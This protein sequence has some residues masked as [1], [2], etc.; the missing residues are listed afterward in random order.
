MKNIHTLIK[1][2]RFT[3]AL[4][5]FFFIVHLNKSMADNNQGVGVK[6]QP[7]GD[8]STEHLLEINISC[9]DL[10]DCPD[11]VGGLAYPV[12]EVIQ[13]NIKYGVQGCSQTL[14]APDQILTNRHCLL[15][16]SIKVGASCS[17]ITV[18]FPQTKQSPRESLACQTIL[19]MSPLYP[20][21]H[22]LGVFPD[23]VIL[24]LAH[25]VQRS[26][27]EVDTSGIPNKT[28][29]RTFP[30][31]YE[32]EKAKNLKV[33]TNSVKTVASGNIKKI[34][35]RSYMDLFS[36]I[37]YNHP[38]SPLLNF[39]CDSDT[40]YGNSGAGLISQEGKI[41]GVLSMSPPTS[42]IPLMG[43]RHNL[44]HYRRTITT[45]NAHCIPPLNADGSTA[46]AFDTTSVQMYSMG[47]FAST[48]HGQILSEALLEELEAAIAK[49][50]TIQWEDYNESFVAQI[51]APENTFEGEPLLPSSSAILRYIKPIELQKSFP[52]TPLCIHS[53][54]KTEPFR[55]MLPRL[56]SP[57]AKLNISEKGR[58]LSPLELSFLQFD[59]KYDAI[60][61]Q[62][63]GQLSPMGTDMKNLF[64]GLMMQMDRGFSRCVYSPLEAY[65]HELYHATRQIENLISSSVTTANLFANEHFITGNIKGANQITIPVCSNQ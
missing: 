45:S 25:P 15:Q 13:G 6:A 41:S 8:K 58:F 47:F 26:P 63:S 2:G 11:Y 34:S 54:R 52:K 59:M 3:L 62:F 1:M 61:D 33:G 19:E 27:I 42:S 20:D 10:E 4:F 9:A 38:H 28:T 12:R 17:N 35:C 39:I 57:L 40:I 5:S 30:V 14:I 56:S 24:Q 48:T 32:Y 18:V 36:S 22:G 44:P 65:C 49:D 21:P 51:Y 60:N 55:L 53:S 31:Y 29:L 23:W 43:T 64:N 37:Y 46:C 7:E 50:K 16:D